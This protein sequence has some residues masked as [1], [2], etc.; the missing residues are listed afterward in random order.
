VEALRV[1]QASLIVG[2]RVNT[3]MALAAIAVGAVV[4]WIGR[5]AKSPASAG[6]DGAT[7]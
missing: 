6:S 7:T 1:D 3:W 2:V 5:T 4:T